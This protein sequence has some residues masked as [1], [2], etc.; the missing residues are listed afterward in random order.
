MIVK[1]SHKSPQYVGCKMLAV[2]IEEL[3]IPNCGL[4]QPAMKS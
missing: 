2:A 3:T 1:R 4:Y